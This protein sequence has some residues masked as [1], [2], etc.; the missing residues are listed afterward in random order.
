MV[1]ER[2]RKVATAEHHVAAVTHYH[3]RAGHPSPR[4]DD[5]R[6][7]LAEV[8]K[9]RHEQPEG[10]EAISP[11]DLVR[12]AE[13]C[14]LT[15]TAGLRD[16]A[17]VILGFASSFR[18]SELANLLLSDVGEDEFGLTLFQRRSKTDQKRKGRYFGIWHGA[19]ESTDPVRALKSW[20]D[21]RGPW[22]G[23]LFCRISRT[24]RVIPRGITGEAINDAIQRAIARAGLDATRYGAH[25]LRAGAVTAAAKIGRTDQEIKE[26]SGHKSTQVME[27]YIRGE[28]LFAGR[29]PLEGVL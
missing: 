9:E 22:V 18:R 11:L 26:M 27:G 8:R 28:R 2:G 16:R 13:A 5:V 15:T 3:R 1:V 7:V 24:G 25:S 19:R 4:N 6:K 20:I 17:L 21:A 12:V 14:D 10:K 29:N 23:P